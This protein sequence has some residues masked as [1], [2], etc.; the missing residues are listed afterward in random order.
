MWVKFSVPDFG[1]SAT[2]FDRLGDVCCVEF[3]QLSDL[4]RS[5]NFGHRYLLWEVLVLR[6]L[7]GGD[8]NVTNPKPKHN[9]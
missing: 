1:D 8:P 4:S 5:L 2:L 6:Q 9:P 7:E 3:I